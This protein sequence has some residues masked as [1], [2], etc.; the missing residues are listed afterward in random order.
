MKTIASVTVARSDYGIYRPVHRRLMQSSHLRLQVIAAGAHFSPR[1]GRTVGELE[2][3]GMPIA[4]RVEIPEE[5]DAD[6]PAGI[7][8]HIGRSIA[9][10]GDVYANLK[11]DLLLV[12]GDRIEMAAAVLA[13]QPFNIPVAHL[14]GG[15]VSLGAIDDVLRHAI[16]Q[17]SAVHFV[18]H[19]DHARRVRQMG[20]D[21]HQVIVSG[22]PALD[23]LRHM[24]LQTREQIHAQHGLSL[25]EK[26]ALVVFHPVTRQPG[27]ASQQVGQLLAALRQAG[28]PCVIGYPNADAENHAIIQQIEAYVQADARSSVFRN[29]GIETYFSLMSHARVMVGNSSSGIIE[30]ASLKLPVVNVGDRQKGRL[31]GVNVIDTPCQTQAIVR[32]IDTATSDALRAAVQTMTNPYGDGHASERIVKHLESLVIDDDLKMRPFRDL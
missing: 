23:N 15:E 1:Y 26:F 4:A 18:S 8:R 12:L 30:A 16:T 24:T 32:A 31:H 7:T 9:A 10:L 13:A 20:Q 17:L 5:A 28:L 25:P 22:A 11:P 29:V 19:E 6:T 2:R 14:H 27:Q 3:D 21:P